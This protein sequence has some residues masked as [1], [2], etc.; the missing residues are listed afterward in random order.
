[1]NRF[2]DK[3]KSRD[4]S[5]AASSDN[6]APAHDD[7]SP[8][9]NLARELKTFC[10]SNTN[11]EEAQ[12]NEFVH[13]PRIVELAESSP[14]AAKEAAYRIRKYLKT[15]TRI[16]NHV[17]YN[18]IMVARILGDN[19]GHTFTRNFDTKFV[20]TI[21]ELLRY[22][23]DWHVQHYLRQYLITLETT[24][25][26]D[27]DLQELLQMWAKEKTK[28]DRSFTDRFPQA[29]HG[30]NAQMAPVPPPR[31][32]A[33]GQVPPPSA[34]VTS[35]GELAARVEEARNSAKLL[36]QFV[37]MTPAAEMDENELIK[38]FTDRCRTSS[39]LIQ[40]YIH[41]NNPPP[42]EDTLLTLIECNDVV[43]V[44]L[45]N[46]QRAML[47][48]RQARGSTSPPVNSNAGP[49]VSPVMASG[50]R[51]EATTSPL[52]ELDDTGMT[53]GRINTVRDTHEAYEYQASDFEVGN[54]FADNH[55]THDSGAERNRVNAD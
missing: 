50:A 23:R 40:S 9:A 46:Q 20:T 22:G 18:A 36:T 33:Y 19:P 15:P 11:P 4:S 2:L 42:D 37:Q 14:A 13:L 39:R 48:A 10:E 8:E 34:Y 45:S 1:M 38:E 24:K 43:S 25:Q 52:I 53:N 5:P 29:R 31:P 30:Y 26:D 28:G 35:P 41:E 21:K 51:Q 27:E 6:E 49:T 54:P 7:D 47:K 3:L 44:A 17:Q 16:S 32:G 55:A 12:G